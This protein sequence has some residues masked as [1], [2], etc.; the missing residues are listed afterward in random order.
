MIGFGIDGSDFVVESADP[1]GTVC[2]LDGDGGGGLGLGRELSGIGVL[3]R[4][5]VVI[6]VGRRFHGERKIWK[7]DIAEWET[8]SSV[9]GK[10]EMIWKFLESCWRVETVTNDMP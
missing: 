6:V 9:R 3:G 4:G 7:S 2:G 10:L 8:V 1:V 5:S